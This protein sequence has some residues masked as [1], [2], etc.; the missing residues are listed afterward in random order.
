M[1]DFTRV[2]SQIQSF[3]Q[4][5]ANSQPRLEEARREA[6]RRLH[7][8]GPAWQL[9]RDRIATARTS[10]L[11]ASWHEPSDTVFAPE[12]PSGAFTVYAADGSQIVSDRHDIALCYL[13]NIG[14]IALHYGPNPQASLTSRPHL[15]LPDDD[16]LDEFQ[17]EQATIVPRRLG[18][19]RLL[20][21]V[22]GL[23]ELTANSGTPA[24]ALF[25]GS[26]ILWP[27]ETEKEEF[28]TAS[29]NTFEEYLEIMRQ[30]RIPIAGYISS[31]QSRDVVNS[32]RLVACPHP[33]ADC[34]NLCPNRVKP[35]PHYVP[36]DC[37]GTESISDADL[38]ME[39]LRPGERS[40][41]FGSSSKI[42]K[43]CS[44]KNQIRFFYLHTGPE[45]ARVEVPAW[46]CDDPDLLAR[47]HSLCYD[48]ARKGDGYPVALAEAH[49]QAVVR[50]AEKAAF[51][52]IM[53]RDFVRTGQKVG[54]TQ[55]AVS[56]RA[57]R[58]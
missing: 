54:I 55:K 51:F 1:L 8:S 39:L 41:I 5:R 35:R 23:V 25:D 33:R 6:V 15:A 30:R 22:A 16:M 49:E 20:E 7:A 18:I 2:V 50:A 3:V 57:R 27:L 37:S 17:G 19:R 44:E 34:E 58:V 48:Q 11:L 9:T 12:S 36:P 52:Q 28:R 46:V 31:P 40:P 14:L 21:E 42:L 4:E 24:L 32:L 47:T 53:Q 29:L 56:K 10:W 26:L 13:L 38:F 45:V 43:L